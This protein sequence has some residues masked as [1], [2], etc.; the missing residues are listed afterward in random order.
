[1]N[2]WT[3]LGGACL[4]APIFQ[5]I[6]RDLRYGRFAPAVTRIRTTV[7][8]VKNPGHDRKDEY[9][10]NLSLITMPVAAWTRILSSGNPD[11]CIQPQAFRRNDHHGMIVAVHVVAML[12]RTNCAT[13]KLPLLGG[14]P[15]ISSPN[16]CR[17][18]SNIFIVIRAIA[19]NLRYLRNLRISFICCS[20]SAHV[21]GRG[22]PR[23]FDRAHPRC[24]V[25]EPASR[26][27]T[28]VGHVCCTRH[29]SQIPL[30]AF[31]CSLFPPTAAPL[32]FIFVFFVSFVSHLI[33]MFILSF[34]S[35]PA[36]RYSLLFL[37]AS[38]PL[39]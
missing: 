9:K 14:A 4:E 38:V 12:K 8:P 22:V 36:T 37:C 21:P 19:L 23:N 20:L 24:R 33:L 32:F 11:T 3:T 39:C 30:R 5:D 26:I 35:L 28:R 34:P 16:P 2:E 27:R 6:A 31:H 15:H 10:L 7:V 13:P 1:M 17:E 29:R 18:R 25:P